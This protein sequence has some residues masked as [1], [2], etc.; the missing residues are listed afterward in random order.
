[1]D[2][3]QSTKY[4]LNEERN[5]FWYSVFWTERAMFEAY[6]IEAYEPFI[7]LAIIIGFPLFV[8]RLGRQGNDDDEPQEGLET[9]PDDWAPRA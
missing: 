4:I 5:V 8:W 7:A 9:E 1:M 3:I 6:E 2:I